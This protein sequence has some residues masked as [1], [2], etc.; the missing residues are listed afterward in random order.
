MV[1]QHDSVD[2]QLSPAQ[3]EVVFLLRFIPDGLTV[4]EIAAYMFISS[5]AATQRVESLVQGSLAER[6]PSGEDRRMVVVRLTPE[7]KKMARK[8]ERHMVEYFGKT[9]SVFSDEELQAFQAI[10]QKWTDGIERE[11]RHTEAPK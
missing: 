11:N 6:V 10:L 5:S 9:L 4:K 8:V 2:L 1:A 3:R 7:G